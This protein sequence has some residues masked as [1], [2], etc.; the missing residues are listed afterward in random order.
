MAAGRGK[1]RVA[2]VLAGGGAHGAYELGAL[3]ALLPA[4]A[5][6]GAQPSLFVGTS[7]GAINAACLAPEASRQLRSPSSTR[8]I[9]RETAGLERACRAAVRATRL[10]GIA[11]RQAG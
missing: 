5:E 2:V 4:L 1:G 9:R 6:R 3:S 10:G 11:R 8:R 7:V